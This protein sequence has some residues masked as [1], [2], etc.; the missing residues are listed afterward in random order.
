MAVEFFLVVGS[1]F[2]IAG[3]GSIMMILDRDIPRDVRAYGFFWLCLSVL[4][5]YFAPQFVTSSKS[6]SDSYSGGSRGSS[7]SGKSRSFKGGRNSGIKSGSYSGGH[8]SGGNILAGDTGGPG[9]PVQGNSYGDSTDSSYSTH[10]S[11]P[12]EE[13]EEKQYCMWEGTSDKVVECTGY[14]PTISLFHAHIYSV[15]NEFGKRECKIIYYKGD[16]LLYQL[17]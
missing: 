2:L 11:W 10:G 3:L 4:F 6:S 14:Y 9:F 17:N 8:S 5:F 1:F 7:Y 16:K 13:K 15:E 12:L